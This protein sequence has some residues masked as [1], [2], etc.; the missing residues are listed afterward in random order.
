MRGVA[1]IVRKDLRRFVADR[2]GAAMTLLLPVVL[3]AL[4]GLL[5]DPPLEA[6][7]LDVLVA[8]EEG[9]P[10]VD[11]VARAMADDPGLSVERVAPGEA[12]RR[13]ARGETSVAVVLPADLGDGLRPRALLG[14]GAPRIRLLFDPAQRA[15]ADVVA[16]LVQKVAVRQVL[17]GLSDPAALR[18]VLLD[19][20]GVVR[21]APLPGSRE[22]WRDFVDAGLALADSMIEEGASLPAPTGLPV[23]LEREEIAAEDSVHG[24]DSHAHAFAGMLA[25]FLLFWA[26]EAAR[27]LVAERDAGLLTRV[28]LT[29]A[30]RWEVLL[31][32]G[33]SVAVVGLAMSAALYGVGVLFFGVRVLGS[34]LGFAAVLASQTLLAAGFSV[35]LVGLGRTERRIQNG[36]TFA[37]LV[38]AFLG[39]AWVPAFLMP[40]WL[41]S[42]GRVLPTWWATQGQAAMTWRG[43]PLDD[44]LVS[45]A[46]LLAWAVA[47]GLV[48]AATFRWR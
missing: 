43:L 42:V 47:C 26:M 16:G 7:P 28:R 2:Q 39:G 4:L 34:P 29:G 30:A 15:S 41:Q 46:A 1:W 18:E 10:A 21:L 27:E 36:G 12:R 25:M 6:R 22:A 20:R 37:I 33:A 35:L 19:L 44:G 48:G 17:S 45:A 14:V 9:G 31:G 8:A 24:Y 40:G 23:A 3:G 13:V 11:S 32:R 38:M 5:L